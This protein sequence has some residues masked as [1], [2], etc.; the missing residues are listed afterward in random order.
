MPYGL[1]DTE[2]SVLIGTLDLSEEWP[3]NG[4]HF[5]IESHVPCDAIHDD[6]PHARAEDDPEII[7]LG[8]ATEQSVE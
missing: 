1:D 5:G 3:P 4:M 8:T 2:P 7:A 6:L